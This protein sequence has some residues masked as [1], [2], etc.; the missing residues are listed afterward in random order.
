MEKSYNIIPGES[1]GPFRLGMRREDIEELNIHPMEMDEDG[2]G[3]T[4]RSVCISVRFDESGRCCRI[5]ARLHYWPGACDG[6]MSFNL[7]GRI[8]N[9]TEQEV[10]ELARSISPHMKVSYGVLEWPSAGL[11]AVKWEAGDDFFE[12]I[13]VLWPQGHEA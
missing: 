4:F 10:I 9:N 6:K 1:I 8:V 12:E 2:S 13:A 7:A 5:G 11:K 3:A